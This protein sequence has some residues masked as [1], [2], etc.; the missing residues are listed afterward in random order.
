MDAR[1]GDGEA[2]LAKVE[3]VL[4]PVLEEHGLGLVD[5]QWRREGRR[6]VLRLFV[7]R[8][9]GA[10]IMD[11]QRLSHEAGDVLDVSGLI[12]ESYDLE[13]SSP[14]LDREL[15]TDREFAWAVGK[16]VR[17]WVRE[18]VE[19]R[20]EFAGRLEGAGPDRLAIAAPDGRTAEVPRALLT[21]ARLDPPF[22]RK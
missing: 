2:F 1:A 8:P 13:V 6:R 18:P 9:G 17:C 10:G 14:G 19:G 20:L 21:K 15:R 16:D 22:R 5:L 4:S 3:A 12:E 7:D 11:C